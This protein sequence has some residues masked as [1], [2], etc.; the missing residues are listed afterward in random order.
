MLRIDARTRSALGI[1]FTLT[2]SR[3]ECSCRGVR[4]R[5]VDQGLKA[6]R[7]IEIVLPRLDFVNERRR[8]FPPPFH[9]LCA[10]CLYFSPRLDRPIP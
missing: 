2:A 9:F 8:T 4:H 7:P 6:T 10:I 3:F 1:L 5:P